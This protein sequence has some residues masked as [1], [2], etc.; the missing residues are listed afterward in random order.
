[1]TLIYTSGTTGPPKGVEVTHANLLFE[2]CAVTDVLPV[3]FGDRITSFQP[4]AH[5]ADR[6]LAL[7]LQEV[8]GT[9]ITVVPDPEQ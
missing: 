4:S 3:E 9:T 8:K 6:L 5:G 7:Y 2:I 1:L